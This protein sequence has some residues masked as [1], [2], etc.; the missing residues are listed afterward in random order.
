[1]S[2]I[3]IVEDDAYLRRDLKEI[4]IKNGHVAETASSV[5]EALHYVYR[6]ESIDLYLL[7]VWLPD[8]EGFAI[9]SEIR[10]QNE[11]PVIFLTVCDDEEY[12]VK[13]L[14]LGGD[15]YIIKPFRTA[16][17]LSR[18]RANLRRTEGN[19][20]ELLLKSGELILNPG[21]ETVKQNGALLKLS[22]IQ[23]ELL[24]K[25]MENGERIVKRDQL[26]EGLWKEPDNAVEDNTLSV[27][28]SRL[29][30]KIGEEYIETIRGF[31]YRFTGKVYRVRYENN[32]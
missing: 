5:S 28:M 30:S 27:N 24:K 29:R 16:E 8:G 25:L 19:H 21:Q 22:P 1:M 12:V 17:L 7:D 10:K 3:L 20:E 2:K 23:Y 13:G 11:K 32:T 26:L 9:C 4:L 14:N 18:I 31:G 6:D 15:D